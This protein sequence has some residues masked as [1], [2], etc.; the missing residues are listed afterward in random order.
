VSFAIGSRIATR[1][2]G[3]RCCARAANG[4]VAAALPTILMKSRRLIASPEAQDRIVTVCTGILEGARSADVRFG[5]LADICSASTHVRFTPESRHVR[6]DSQCPLWAK[7]GHAPSL[8]SQGPVEN[9]MPRSGIGMPPD[10]SQHD[11]KS[12][13]VGHYNVPAMAEPQTNRLCFRVL[14][15]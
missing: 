9:G 4:H 5:S 11:E 14:V 3:S 13:H 8:A 10:K 1:R 6:C 15:R 7:S 2:R 12:D